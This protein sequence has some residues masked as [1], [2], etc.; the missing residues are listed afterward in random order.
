MQFE[1]HAENTWVNLEIMNFKNYLANFC[2][3]QLKSSQS[4]KDRVIL[5]SY[6]GSNQINLKA[7]KSKNQSRHS[8]Y[9]QLF[10]K[11]N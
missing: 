2:T 6:L 11:Y 5:N 10:P 3:S 1:I 8:W 4:W 7:N 9:M